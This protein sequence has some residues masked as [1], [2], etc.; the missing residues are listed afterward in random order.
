MIRTIVTGYG[1]WGQI[2]T[3]RLVKHPHYF[4]CGI[5]DPSLAARERARVE[6]NLHTY[7]TL[8]DAIN[9]ESPELVCVCT[10][11]AD[12]PGA[13]AYSATRYAHVLAAKPGATTRATAERMVHAADAKGVALVVD[14]TL[15]AAPKWHHIKQLVPMLGDLRRI[16]AV[17]TTPEGRSTADVLDDLAVHDLSLLV[18]L[19]EAIDWRI[20]SSFGDASERSIRMEHGDVEALVTA[21]RRSSELERE[22]RIIGTKGALTWNQLTDTVVCTADGGTVMLG[23]DSVDPVTAR[24]WFLSSV[25]AGERPDNRRVFLD[26]TRLVEDAKHGGLGY[27]A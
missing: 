10:P 25:I 12:T 5:H 2:L 16:D 18:D 7:K 6:A 1:F 23:A 17:R 27:A 26:V 19:D 3:K 9:W 21:E 15:T 13:S 22:F 14:Y 24:L 11:I 20:T 8:E 4:V